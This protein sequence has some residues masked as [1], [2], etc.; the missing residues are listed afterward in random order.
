MVKEH[1]WHLSPERL[2]LTPIP[3]DGSTNEAALTP[4]TGEV[5]VN[6]ELM[7]LSTEG[8][9]S[10]NGTSPAG[11]RCQQCSVDTSL[12]GDRCQQRS[13]GSSGVGVNS[14]PLTL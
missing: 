1:R 6:G 13:A 4:I 10:P 14:A 3:R 9:V 5:S 7:H 12:S 8:V 11:D 2:V